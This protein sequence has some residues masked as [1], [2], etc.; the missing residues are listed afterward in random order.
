MPIAMAVTALFALG[1]DRVFYAPLQ[2][3]QCEARS[4]S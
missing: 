4:L 2:N 3:R 1:I